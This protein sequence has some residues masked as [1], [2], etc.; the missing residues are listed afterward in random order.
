ML[1]DLLNVE[2]PLGCGHDQLEGRLVVQVNVAAVEVAED[3]GC[4]P[5]QTLVAVNESMVADQRVQPSRRL[6]LERRVGLVTED[7]CPRPRTRRFEEPDID[8]GAH[9]QQPRQME[10]VLDVEVV[11]LAHTDPS[12]S[13]TSAQRSTI[14]CALSSTRAR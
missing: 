3:D 4:Q 6:E 5:G 7:T 10:E 14:R 12:R 8:D 2:V 9:L 13:R 11:E 1:G